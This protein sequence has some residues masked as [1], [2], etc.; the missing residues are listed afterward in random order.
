MLRWQSF[1]PGECV[2]SVPQKALHSRRDRK[3]EGQEN[4]NEREYVKL[5][6]INL[7]HRQVPDIN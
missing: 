1:C 6:L 2:R 7:F 4:K 5:L 3:V